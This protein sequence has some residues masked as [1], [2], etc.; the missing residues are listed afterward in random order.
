MSLKIGYDSS[1]YEDNMGRGGGSMRKKD[2]QLQLL[3]YLLVNNE[4]TISQLAEV[5]QVSEMT[6]RRDL[7]T[8]EGSGLVKRTRLGVRAN[9]P[10]YSEKSLEDRRRS[11]LKEKHQIAKKA[12]EEVKDGDVIMI[13]AGTTTQTLAEYLVNKKDLV[14]ITN[15]LIIY[16]V[17]KDNPTTKI[18]LAG[19]F[20][21]PE[22]NYSTLGTYTQAFYQNFKADKSFLGMLS[23]DLETGLF[24]SNL[25]V[26][27]T[28]RAMIEATKQTYLLV[29]HCKFETEAMF[30][31][32]DIDAVQTIITDQGFDAS[33]HD[34]PDSVHLMQA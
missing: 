30:K 18:F 32:A 8:M 7:E 25:D 23:V 3:N 12:A 14:V 15:D 6:I 27:Q 31:V 22:Y 16:N 28:K 24:H 29:D 13:D 1:L 20:I 4:R 19:G 2:R 5:F 17:L 10:K 21:H 34:I 26:A 11:Q 33:R 9:N